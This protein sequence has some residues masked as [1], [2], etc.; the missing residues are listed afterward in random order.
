M[1]SVFIRINHILSLL[2]PFGTHIQSEQNVH[3]R[4][5]HWVSIHWAS[6]RKSVKLRYLFPLLDT[7]VDTGRCL[8]GPPGHG[9]VNAVR[10]WPP[11]QVFWPPPD[12]LPQDVSSFPI[13]LWGKTLHLVE[14]LSKYQHLLL[15]SIS[16][17]QKLKHNL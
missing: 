12:F 13:E 17:L 10:G 7:G 4:R 8:W 6:L 1:C 14:N 16:V 5:I 9:P 2:K 11:P 15:F 3:Q